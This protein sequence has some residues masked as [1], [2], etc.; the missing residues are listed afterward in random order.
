M[1]DADKQAFSTLIAGV[2]AYHRTAVTP[3]VISVYWRGCAPYTLEQVTKAIDVLTADPEA[4]RF[5]PKI[6]DIVRVLQGTQ[7]DR[8]LIAWGKVSG[9]M[10]YVGAYRDVAFDDP[11]I[12]LCVN[13][14][15]GWPKFCRTPHDEQGYLQHAF[16]KAYQAYANRPALTEWPSFL[17]GVSEGA[18]QYAKV[19]MAPPRIKLVGDVTVARRVVEGGLAV[20]R[21]AAAQVVAALPAALQGEAA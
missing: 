3:A 8:S 15:G 1:V 10:G 20:A 4:G 11:L 14:L 5:A 9:A 6:A 18:E 13:D 19:G 16:S 7:T 17:V 12:H 21:L 2:F